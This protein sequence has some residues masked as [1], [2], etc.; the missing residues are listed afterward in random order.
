[1]NSAVNYA[2]VI[3]GS[4]RPHAGWFLVA[5]NQWQDRFSVMHWNEK[6]ACASDAFS[7]LCCVQ[8]VEELVVHWMTTGSLDYPFATTK[9]PQSNSTPALHLGAQAEMVTAE[10]VG[11]LIVDRA[12]LPRLL[13]ENP[14]ALAPMLEALIMALQEDDTHAGVDEFA[15]DLCLVT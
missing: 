6:L 11:E 8:H 3:C 2:C 10:I 7:H 4:E 12:S 5:T 15:D 9:L 1:M 14:Y 13:S